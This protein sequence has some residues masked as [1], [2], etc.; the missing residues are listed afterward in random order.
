[1]STINETDHNQA[2]AIHVT[3]EI[4]PVIKTSPINIR[5]AGESLYHA[6][7]AQKTKLSLEMTSF[8]RLRPEAL[9]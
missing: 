5:E 3:P 2:A 8:N 7:L 1:M 9:H 6:L 4:P